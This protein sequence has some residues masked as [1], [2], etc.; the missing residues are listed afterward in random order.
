M[1]LK[2]GDLFGL[3]VTAPAEDLPYVSIVYV[4]ADG[5]AVELYRGSPQLGSRMRSVT[6]GTGGPR[7]ARYQVSAPYGNELV[8]AL[9]S[10]S[11]R[12]SAPSSTITAPSGSS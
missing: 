4:Q 3:T 9:A 5:S 1:A 7:V 10:E 11:S 2:N 8:V 12:C 6:V